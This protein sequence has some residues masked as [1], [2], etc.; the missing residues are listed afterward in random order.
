MP[1][2]VV[3][4]F[5]NHHKF[6][7]GS[8]IYTVYRYIYNYWQTIIKAFMDFP[9]VYDDC[10]VGAGGFGTLGLPANTE[11]I[12]TLRTAPIVNQHYLLGRNSRRLLDDFKNN[13]QLA[14]HIIEKAGTARGISFDWEGLESEDIKRMG[15][16]IE[17]IR[18]RRAELTISAYINPKYFVTESLVTTAYN[19]FLDT[20]KNVEGCALISAYTHL[21]KEQ[22]SD[23]KEH[24]VYFNHAIG[25]AKL[26][27]GRYQGLRYKFLV[28]IH[29]FE[30]GNHADLLRE[31]IKQIQDSGLRMLPDAIYNL[32]GRYGLTAG[33]VRIL[34]RCGSF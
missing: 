34:K 3:V 27:R 21:T 6:L 15:K 10:N 2:L 19:G 29:E 17:Q 18:A 26:I 28:G 5:Q 22:T 4:A 31:T 23:G 9:W 13:Q 16:I 7:S 33:E 24:G 11:I 1:L 30:Y 8:S 14:E 32:S 20:L 25:L 12:N